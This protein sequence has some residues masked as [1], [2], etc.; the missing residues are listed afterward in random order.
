MLENRIWQHGGVV[1]NRPDLMIYSF[2]VQL[3]IVSVIVVLLAVFLSAATMWWIFLIYFAVF[4]F[5]I[6][7]GLRRDD[8]SR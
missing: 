5:V 3:V 2:I 7:I 8:G 6:W 4:A 1:F